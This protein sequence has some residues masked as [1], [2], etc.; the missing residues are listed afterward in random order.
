M[1]F[2][3]AKAA[4]KI[5]WVPCIEGAAC[6]ENEVDRIDI[7][8][9]LGVRLLGVTYSESNALG[10]G[11]KEGQRRRPDQIRQGLRGAHE[12]GGHAHRRVPLRS[13]DRL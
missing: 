6:I 7:L 10:N 5:A 11:M 4:G 1:T 12:Q 9:G 2:F 13:E 8:Y 3:A